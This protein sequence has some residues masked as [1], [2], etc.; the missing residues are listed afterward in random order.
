MANKRPATDI[1][2]DGGGGGSRSGGT[3]AAIVPE[4]PVWTHFPNK[5]TARLTWLE[6]FYH[7]DEGLLQTARVFFENPILQTATQ[8]GSGGGGGAVAIGVTEDL[9]T[10]TAANAYDF[11]QPWVMQLRMTSPY[12]IINKVGSL[13]TAFPTSTSEPSW[14]SYFDQK[15]QFYH[16]TRCDW[17][18]TLDFGTPMAGTGVTKNEYQNYGIW[19]F[20]RYTN[21][22]NP[23]TAW[24]DDSANT[25]VNQTIATSNEVGNTTNSTGDTITSKMWTGTGTTV[26]LTS[27]DYFRMGGWKHKYVHWETIK[28]TKCHLSGSYTFGQCKMDIKSQ[29][30][31]SN[32]TGV[33]NTTEEWSSCGSTAI[34]PENLSIIAVQ[35]CARTAT[36]SDA[37]P[38]G[39]KVPFSVR[40][41]TDHELVFA[42]LRSNYKFP[43]PA[44]C[45]NNG[46]T[47]KMIT[48]EVN[49]RRGAMY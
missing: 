11:A 12:N 9:T 25:I 41:K 49:F 14:L 31:T 48:D 44:L 24:Q 23:P 39:V 2:D 43:T 7:Q 4:G 19:V 5:Q 34:F 46:A 16:Q 20:W 35:D 30:A 28:S 37:V 8:M 26:Y 15:Y 10:L 6:T 36:F 29:A 1:P 32:P 40:C 13:A 17:N 18:V 3:E 47:T 42:D 21:N 22:D 27:D 45:N 38:H 33:A